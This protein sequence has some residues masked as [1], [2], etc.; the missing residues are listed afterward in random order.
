[1]K[2]FTAS[3]L[4]EAVEEYEA[5][6]AYVRES[7]RRSLKPSSGWQRSVRVRLTAGVNRSALKEER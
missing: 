4:E 7:R 3:R 6:R 5:W 1:M 2:E